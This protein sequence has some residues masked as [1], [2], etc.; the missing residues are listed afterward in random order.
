[1]STHFKI[2]TTCRNA[3]KWIAQ[4]MQS[5]QNQTY[6][7]WQAVIVDD[8]SVDGTW[9]IIQKQ[10][11]MSDKCL[12]LQNNCRKYQLHSIVDAIKFIQPKKE[13]VIVTL[14]GD[15]WFFDNEVLEY[16]AKVYEDP[17]IWIT[18]G[19]FI[20]SGTKK[21]GPSARSIPIDWN[22]RTGAWAFSHLRTF[23][24]FLW[25]LIKDEDFRTSW[26]GEY[27]PAGGDNAFMR[28]MVEMAGPPHR[29]FIDQILYVYNGENPTSVHRVTPELQT[30]CSNEVK[31]KKPYSQISKP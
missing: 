20:I 24:Y 22:V 28:P 12:L 7:N 3:E 21:R 31:K 27:Y 4:S 6:T 2:I 10:A 29:K 25:R 1:M 15:D 16:L 5:V 9:D 8:C 17:S 26:S 14:D 11:K 18:W 30:R 13:D 23:K 19:S